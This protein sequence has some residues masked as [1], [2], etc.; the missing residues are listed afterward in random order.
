MRM[1]IAVVG[2]GLVACS[3]EK[4]EV[5]GTTTGPTDLPTSGPTTS[6]TT[7]GAPT[8][9]STTG[10]PTGTG[11]TSSTTTTDT[12]V[13]TYELEV[14]L[15]ADDAWSLWIDGIPIDQQVGWSFA[16]TSTT[17]VDLNTD[18]PHVVAVHAYDVYGVISG[19]LSEVKLDGQV[20]GL[21]GSGSWRVM[22]T[23]PP[24]DW[25]DPWF[26]DSSWGAAP[27]C[28]ASDVATWGGQPASLMATGAQWVWPRPCRSLGDAWFRLY[29]EITP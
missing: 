27:L 20:I 4:P 2:L 14:N 29:F 18:G 11:T 15:T 28:T 5:P 22:D 10:A 24:P 8:G 12:A 1:V 16:T 3:T 21:T 13:V 6:T 23:Q 25:V 17:V 26:D 7:S 19:F 9:S